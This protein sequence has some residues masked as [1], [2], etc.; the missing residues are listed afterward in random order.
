MNFYNG[1]SE[2]NGNI[3]IM[4]TLINIEKNGNVTFIFSKFPIKKM[5]P[6]N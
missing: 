4:P 5:K 2:R 3:Y 1:I 6:Y